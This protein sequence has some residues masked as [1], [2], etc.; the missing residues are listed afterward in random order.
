MQTQAPSSKSIYVP[1]QLQAPL[2]F[3]ELLTAIKLNTCVSTCRIKGSP[4]QLAFT[5]QNSCSWFGSYLSQLCACTPLVKVRALQQRHSRSRTGVPALTHL[6]EQSKKPVLRSHCYI[7]LGQVCYRG[8]TSSGRGAEKPAEM[9]GVGGQTYLKLLQ[10][11]W[12][13]LVCQS[14]Y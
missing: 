6:Q 5:E 10:P 11:S 1:I 12:Q 4:F 2:K 8:S 7:V 9:A 13:E 14:H 3:L